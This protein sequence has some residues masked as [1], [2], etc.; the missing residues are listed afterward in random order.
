M[1]ATGREAPL[2]ALQPLA[3]QRVGHQKQRIARRPVAP[4]AERVAAHRQHR[5]PGG[6]VKA[7]AAAVGVVGHRSAPQAPQQPGH[8]EAPAHHPQGRTRGWFAPQQIRQ[9][10]GAG[11][12]LPIGD[13]LGGP[14][15][16]HQP[17]RL[18]FHQQATAAEAARGAGHQEADGAEAGGAQGAFRRRPF[19]CCRC[20]GGG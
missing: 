1:V 5:H 16:P 12:P 20:A 6:Q 10:R 9:E 4:V 3:L 13:H 2:T 15:L 7:V 18:Q 14:Y 11:L 8:I 19:P 17:R